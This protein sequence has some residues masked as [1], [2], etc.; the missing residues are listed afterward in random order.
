M[1]KSKYE[2]Y[3]D[4]FDIPFAKAFLKQ[5]TLE[6]IDGDMVMLTTPFKSALGVSITATFAIGTAPEAIIEK[7]KERFKEA[8][9]K[10]IQTPS[11]GEDHSVKFLR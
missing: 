11:S 5:C 4:G 3:L 9:V 6:F 7:L 2:K 8:T 10:F 1:R